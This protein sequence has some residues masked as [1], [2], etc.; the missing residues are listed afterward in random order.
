MSLEMLQ[1][2]A[3]ELSVCGGAILLLLV[4]MYLPDGA[5]KHLASL[6]ALLL[7]VALYLSTRF[8]GQGAIGTVYFG[9]AFTQLCKRLLIVATLG[10]VLGG[11][12]FIAKVAPRRQGEYYFLILMCLTGMMLLPGARDLIL[13]IVSFE[14]MGIPL[15]VLTAFV[16]D[17]ASPE[18]RLAATKQAA[19]ASLK[20]YL[21]G[22]A[23]TTVTLF[24]LSLLVGGAGSTRLDALLA[25]P[26]T[27]LHIAGLLLV[28]GG[29]G[30]K[31]GAVPFHMWVPDTYQGAL[32]P[33]VAFLSVAPKAAGMATLMVLSVKAVPSSIWQPA[34]TVLAVVS[35]T[36]GNLMA[37][38]Q[39]NVKRL[40]GYSGVAQ[41]G[42]MLLALCVGGSYALAMLLFY[43]CGYVVT[44]LGTFLVVHAVADREGDDSLDG[45]SGLARRSPWL[46]LSLL[47]FLL[48]LAGIPF[49]I[50]FWSKL[51]LFMAVYQAGQ[52]WLVVVGAVLAVVGLFYYLQVARA[53]YMVAPAKPQPLQVE[54]WLAVMIVV[55]LLLVTGL[56]AYPGPLLE[57]CQQAADA[58]LLGR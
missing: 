47:M 13:L 5:R 41:I 21:V 34:L 12:D 40:L 57:V 50:G 8:D 48:S 37:L 39:R 51:Y 44:N 27:P 14:L 10:A 54:P 11:R 4:D 45:L 42:Y 24:G 28:L 31:I 15:Y 25:A 49:V 2:I 55:C 17:E 35:M 7:V 3:V 43:L 23:S 32:T 46:G 18:R 53:A 56:G 19:E 58:L 1:P 36:V 20:L 29:M 9:S 6:T 16:R 52:G 22:A 30:F 26:A 33:V 38:P